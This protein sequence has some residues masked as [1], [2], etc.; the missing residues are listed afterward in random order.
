M[1]AL[2]PTWMFRGD[3]MRLFR[4]GDE[5]PSD[6]Y[7]APDKFNGADPKAFD[8]DNDGRAGGAVVQPKRRGRPP[9]VKPDAV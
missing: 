1:I 3:E 7:D 9:K 4:E 2:H 8:H 5:I 6:W